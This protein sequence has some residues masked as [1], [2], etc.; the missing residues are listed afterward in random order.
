M[1]TLAKRSV[2]LRHWPVGYYFSASFK[3]RPLTGLWKRS[4]AAKEKK[5]AFCSACFPVNAAVFPLLSFGWR[6]RRKAA[7]LAPSPQERCAAALL[8]N[9]LHRTPLCFINPP[10]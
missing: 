4:A 7:P 2:D 9:H 10:N 3:R 5:L 8:F 1:I 6:E